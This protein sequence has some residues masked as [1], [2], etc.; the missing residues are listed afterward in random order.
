MYGI[1]VNR[2][3]MA[4]CPFHNDKNPSM[5]VDKRFH[6]FACQADG[7]AVDFV[8]RLFGLPSR[9]AAVKIANDFGIGYDSGRKPSVR[10]RIREPTPE[11]KYRAE[12]T[13]CCK[14]LTDYFHHLR[15][16][17]RQ[18][19]PQ[20]PEDE[21]HPLFVEALQRE[22]HIEYLLDVLLYGTAE[23]KKALVTG[24][25]KE[26]IKLERRIAGHTAEYDR[27]GSQRKSGLVTD[28]RAVKN[29]IRN[30][31]TVFQNDPVL[32]G[33][34]RYNILTE[35]I[36]I[37]K[38]L[39]WSKP[40]ATLNDTDLNYLMLYL[41][42]K[43]GLTSEKKIEKAISIVADC[44]KYHPIRDYL[45]SLK[46][47]GTERIRYA[48]TRYLGAEDSEYTYECLRLFMLG[49]IHRV[50]KPGCKFEVML[51]LVGG[52]GAGKSTFFRLLAVM[53][54]WFPD[55]LK[56]IDD[57]NVYRKMQGHWIIEMSEMIATANAKSIEDIKSFISRAKETYK[58]PYETHPADRLRQCVFG[59]SSNT[60]DFLPLDRSGNRRFLPIMVHA[61]NAKVHILEDE[62]ASR[63]YIDLMWAEAMFFYHNFPVRLTLSKEM[64][65]E[66][67][68]LQKQF[69]PE[70]TK[71]GLIQSFLDNYNGTQVC[72]KLIYT[73]ALNHSF[74]E[75]KQWEIREINEIMNNSIEGWTAFSNPRIF[76]KYGRQRG[77]ERAD[78]GNE[79]SATDS[80]LPDGFRELTE[81]EAQQ[82]ELP[83]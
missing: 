81:E 55:D 17:K 10:A 53:D 41:E 57:D 27:G 69:M 67:K 80:D 74:D 77:W 23:E 12:E 54:E 20:Q 7:D 61:E 1:R 59:G 14:V 13:R 49:A 9:E 58:V 83:F 15:T 2:H 39:W 26:V 75:P 33:A 3:G 19:A 79:L 46:W 18:Y 63:A 76:A 65:K 6:C 70:D 68:V 22:S 5:K 21:W 42:D 82:I 25:R 40:T 37:V 30:C 62:A 16:W 29:S 44:N 4:V 47:D 51:C 56:R 45:N 73:E 60:M 38:P 43:Y 50:F 72:S 35:R 66:L 64:N 48:L 71:A 31:L 34:V 52:Q 36:D 24:Q 8:S 32:Q 11:Q 28:K 78:S